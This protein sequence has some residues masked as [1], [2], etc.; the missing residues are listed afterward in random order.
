[1]TTNMEPANFLIQLEAP[2][3]YRIR[4]IDN[5]GSPNHLP[6]AFYFNRFA[7]ARLKRYWHRFMKEL[8][9]DFPHAITDDMVRIL[10]TDYA[11]TSS[12]QALQLTDNLLLGKGHHKV[13]YTYPNRPMWCVKV[14]YDHS[15]FDVWR[16]LRYRRA[17]ELMGWPSTMLTRYNGLVETNLGTGW[18]YE[19]IVDYDGQPSQ[20]LKDYILAA[21]TPAGMDELKSLI[22]EFRHLWQE[23]L[24]I[25]S[26][27]NPENFAVQ[28][29]TPTRHRLRIVDNIGSGSHLPIAFY[30]KHFAR[31]RVQRYWKRFLR[32]MRRDHPNIISE[33]FVIAFENFNE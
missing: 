22:E 3:T 4:I 15:S 12:S 10:D 19:R 8:K 28:R 33:D 9:R 2:S 25:V 26:D 24:V 17:R 11:D 31:K 6:L 27:T 23:E 29:V 14:V 16:E 21:D 18:V 20:S 5:I 32:E 13:V 30:S 1:M 7:D